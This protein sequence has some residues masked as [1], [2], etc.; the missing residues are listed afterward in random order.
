MSSWVD[1]RLFAFRNPALSFLLTYLYEVHVMKCTFH[2]IGTAKGVCSY[3]KENTADENAKKE[4]AALWKVF[5]VLRGTR[6]P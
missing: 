4:E 3:A 2:S 1:P 6:F 5:S